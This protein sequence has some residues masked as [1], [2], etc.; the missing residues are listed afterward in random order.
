M[1]S[2]AGELATEFRANLFRKGRK[3]GPKSGE[4]KGGRHKARGK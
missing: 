1:P 3:D 2:A 4:I